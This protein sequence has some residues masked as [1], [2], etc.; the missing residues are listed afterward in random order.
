MLLQTPS[1]EK[2]RRFRPAN[3]YEKLPERSGSCGAYRADAACHAGGHPSSAHHKAV[4]RLRAG[5]RER[6]CIVVYRALSALCDRRVSA[7]DR[8]ARACDGAHPDQGGCAHGGCD[9]GKAHEPSRDL[10]PQIQCGRAGK[11]VGICQQALHAPSGRRIQ[12]WRHG[13]AFPAVHQS[14]I[15]LRPGAGASG[16]RHHP[17]DGV[18]H[19]VD[20]PYEAE[21]GAG[22]HEERCGGIWRQLRRHFRHPED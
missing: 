18:R 1:A 20:R 3:V 7:H 22:V 9:D 6:T 10:L 8:L 15:F 21:G 12:P 14:D 2:T 11:P 5:E 17:C 19:G 16:V 4:V 13:G